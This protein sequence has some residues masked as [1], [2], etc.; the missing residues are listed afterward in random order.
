MTPAAASGSQRVGGEVGR[1]GLPARHEVL[2][3]L[4]QR[5]VDGGDEPRDEQR[6]ARRRPQPAPGQ[7]P[8]R[9]KASTPNAPAWSTLSTFLTGGSGAPGPDEAAKMR[10]HVGGHHAPAPAR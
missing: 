3:H 9:E 4:V 1:I 6:P 8:G 2:V 5:P 7:R 10:G